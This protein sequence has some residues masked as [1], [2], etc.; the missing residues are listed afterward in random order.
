MRA[1]SICVGFHL[2]I[3]KSNRSAKQ[4]LSLV[5]LLLL[6]LLLSFMSLL[7]VIQNLVVDHRCNKYLNENRKCVVN[8]KMWCKKR[9][10]V[11]ISILL[12]HTE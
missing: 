3:Q 7:V 9:I 2:L 8:N 11:D 5:V 4:K 10:I 6:S 1:D 12:L